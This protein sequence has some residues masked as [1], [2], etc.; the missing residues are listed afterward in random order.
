MPVI[1]CPDCGKSLRVN[2]TTI[3]KRVRCPGCEN[4]FVVPD[5]PVVELAEVEEEEEEERVKPRPRSRRPREKVEED[6]DPSP[7]RP[8][9]RKR[10]D[11]DDGVSYSSAPLIYGILSCVL[12]CSLLIGWYFA[13]KAINGANQEMD[14]LPGGKRS[15]NARKQLQLAKTLGVVG[16]CLSGVLCVIAIILKVVNA[17]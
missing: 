1:Q 13:F 16:M 10:N 15:H 9:R 8:R 5:A 14:R 3:G 2:D 7:R 11:D 6:E 12:S 17:N 4:P